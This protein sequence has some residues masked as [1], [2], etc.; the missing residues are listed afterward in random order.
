MG[1]VGEGHQTEQMQ[2]ESSNCSLE[3]VAEIVHILLTCEKE[4]LTPLIRHSP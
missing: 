2:N 4:T 1:G 3:N